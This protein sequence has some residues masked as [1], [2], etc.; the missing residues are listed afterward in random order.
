MKMVSSAEP[1]ESFQNVTKFNYSTS[2]ESNGYYYIVTRRSSAT[3]RLAKHVPERYAVVKNRRSSLDN[4]F[5]Y[6]GTKHVSGT[7]HT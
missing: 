1:T 2:S 4:G 5:S 7:T 3:Q 6:H